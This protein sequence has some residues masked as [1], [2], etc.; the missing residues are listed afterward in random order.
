MKKKIVMPLLAATCAIALTACGG[1]EDANTEVEENDV[2]QSEETY[3]LKVG[4]IAPP[5]EAYAIGF[6]AYAEAVE[7]ATDGR[8]EFEIFDNGSLGGER[9]L[10]EGVQ[11]GNLD[12]SL[13]TTGV[14]SNFTPEVTALEF[15]FLF[16][17]LDHAYKT[18]DGEIGQEIL[19]KMS[20][21]GF[22]GISFWENGQR[23]LANNKR[24]I[25]TPEDA[26]GLQMR[27]IESDIL[28]DTYESIGTNPTPMAFPEV[29]GGLQQGVIDGTDQSYGVIWSTNT[30]EQLPYFSESG[31]YYASA[32]LI[33]NDELYQSMPEDIQ[34]IIV[35]LGKEYAEVQREISQELE[36]EQRE[37]LL[38]NGVDIVPYEEFDVEGFRELVEPVYEKHADDYGDL[39]ER[40][41]DVE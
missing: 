23:H 9:E 30:Y 27:T 5:E 18:L 35:D 17:D 24:P 34:S 7:E 8:V 11:L 41:L 6:E 31:L 20:D 22:K 21:A 32:T 39:V 16:R 19:D 33:I 13:I 26:K 2:D 40:I 15:P 4:H 29:Y 36:A 3:T 10:A 12:M 25:R 28:L 38:E 14:M 1:T 37:N